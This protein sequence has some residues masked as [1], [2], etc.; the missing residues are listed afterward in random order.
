MQIKENGCRYRY[1]TSE[2]PKKVAVNS[3]RLQT[4]SGAAPGIVD[5]DHKVRPARKGEA[6]RN[7]F[8]YRPS[9]WY[10]LPGV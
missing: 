4:N 8:Q 7:T 2:A 5:L 10:R 6:R 3:R 9:K 1:A